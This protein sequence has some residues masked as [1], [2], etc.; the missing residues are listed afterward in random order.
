[1]IMVDDVAR[2]FLE[3]P[4]VRQVCGELPE[5]DKNAE[6]VKK[7]KVSHLRTS[8]YGTRDAAMNWQEE[9]ARD[10][11]KWGSEEES[12]IHVCTGTRGVT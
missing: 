3:A 6:D 2:A 4:A 8:L 1:M 5:E 12:T 11:R 7:D 10:M 9:V